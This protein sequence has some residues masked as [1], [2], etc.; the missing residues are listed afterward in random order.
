MRISHGNRLVAVGTPR[1]IHG[2]KL[3]VLQVKIPSST[4]LRLE[5]EWIQRE[6]TGLDRLTDQKLS[7]YNQVL[8]EQVRELEE[9]L[10]ALPYHPRYHPLVVPD[11]PFEIRLRTNGPAEA[12]ELDRT[13][14]SMEASIGRMRNG[15][16]LPSP[17]GGL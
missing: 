13:I 14:A 16:G 3:S 7:I 5:L 9:E 6:E 1:Y 4:L 2:P 11:G 8:R 17:A 12:H 15:E 10:A